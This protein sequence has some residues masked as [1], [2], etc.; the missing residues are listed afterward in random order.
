MLNHFYDLIDE[1]KLPPGSRFVDPYDHTIFQ[2]Q[3]KEELPQL[4]NRIITNRE[5]KGYPKLLE[6]ELRQLVIANLFESCPASVME[7]Y[8]VKRAAFPQ[9]SQMLS[10]VKALAV[11]NTKLNNVS[12]QKRE[13]RALKC[14]DNCVFHSNGSKWSKTATSVVN[15]FAGLDNLITSEPE[16]ALGVCKM[17]GG[18]SLQSKVKFSLESVLAAVTPEQLKTYLRLYGA[19]GYGKCW[20]FSEALSNPKMRSLL[21]KKIEVSYPQTGATLLKQFTTSQVEKSKKASANG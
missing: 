10:V 6:S 16:K 11:E 7:K 9:I 13:N 3:I 14:L 18:C 20:I 15:S 2:V 19:S 21:M 5:D 4:I 17:C 1:K 8:F 12:L